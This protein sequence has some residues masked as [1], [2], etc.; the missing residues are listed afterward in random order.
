LIQ[1]IFSFIFDEIESYVLFCRLAKQ[2][3]E[4]DHTAAKNMQETAAPS[5]F[6]P[7][8]PVDYY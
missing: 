8:E 4:I 5:K 1:G 7:A 2:G 6:S 3:R